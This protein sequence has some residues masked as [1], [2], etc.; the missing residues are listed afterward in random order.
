MYGGNKASWQNAMKSAG[1][2]SLS[3]SIAPVQWELA[4]AFCADAFVWQATS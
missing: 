2:S 3:E 1:T 4:P